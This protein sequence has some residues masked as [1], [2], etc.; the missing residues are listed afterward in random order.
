MFWWRLVAFNSV[1]RYWQS[2]PTSIVCLPRIR[3]TNPFRCTKMKNWNGK[4][5]IRQFSFI[6]C[7]KWMWVM[8]ECVWDV[9]SAACIISCC[10]KWFF[11]TINATTLRC[12]MET[13]MKNLLLAN[14]F[15][16]TLARHVYAPKY[17]FIKNMVREMWK[18]EQESI[19]VADIA[20]V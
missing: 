8:C 2:Q 6:V 7:G 1:P 9:V 15:D 11:V 12:R 16:C 4:G 19:C 14:Y 5:W 13:S 20:P 3:T 10:A 17:I 18:N